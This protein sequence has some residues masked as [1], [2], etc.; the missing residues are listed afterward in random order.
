MDF[1]LLKK[2]WGLAISAALMTPSL[3]GGDNVLLV[4]LDDVGVDRVRSYAV[5]A[6][7]GPTPTLDHLAATGVKFDT[8]WALPICSPTR[9]AV[10]TGRYGFRN[11]VRWNVKDQTGSIGL[12]L[13]EWTIPEVLNVG[14][15]SEIRTAAIGKW[16]LGQHK[17]LTEPPPAMKAGFGLYS[18][19]LWNLGG[20]GEDWAFWNF[21]KTTPIGRVPVTRYATTDEIEDA[22]RAIELFG[23]APWFVYLAPHSAHIPYHAPPDDLHDRPLEGIPLDSPPVHHKAM[24]QALDTEL[25]RLL[26]SLAPSVRARTTV[27]ILGD[28]GSPNSSIEPPFDPEHGKGTVYE[29]GVHVPLIISGAAVPTGARGRSCKALVSATDIFATTGDLFGIDTRSIVPSDVVLDS[30][31][32]APYL[33]DP[34]LPSIRSMLYTERVS[35]Q[36]HGTEYTRHQRAARNS[37]FK[38]IRDDLTGVDQLFDLALDPLEKRNLLDLGPDL[39]DEVRQAYF[40]LDRWLEEHQL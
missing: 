28:N 38:L 2:T 26:D 1:R 9:A 35:K 3:A 30:V 14:S 17:L 15:L 23:D 22:R 27:I 24:V 10:L 13:H 36:T 37:R 16:H 20:E 25:G 39:E 29:G 12:S 18:G 4:L 8:C 19:N 5:T 11:G 32:L 31:S 21:M 6:D 34:D 40:E 7:C 33:S